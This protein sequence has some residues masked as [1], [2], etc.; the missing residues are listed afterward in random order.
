MQEQHNVANLK[1]HIRVISLSMA[2]VLDSSTM[3]LKRLMSGSGTN[4]VS[5]A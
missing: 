5:G 2:L 4:R 1:A 3:N